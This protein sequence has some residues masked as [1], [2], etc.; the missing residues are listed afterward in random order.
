MAGGQVRMVWAPEFEGE[1]IQV[2]V[3]MIEGTPQK[4]TLAV[5][6]EITAVIE[7]IDREYRARHDGQVLL[8]AHA[9]LQ[10]VPRLTHRC[11]S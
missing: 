5:I 11:A 3:S 10:R 6:N 2:N 1:F 9:C 8:A 4:R 7:D